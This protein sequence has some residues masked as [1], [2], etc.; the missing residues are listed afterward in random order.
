LRG[1]QA[2]RVADLRFELRERERILLQPL[3]GVLAALANA[4]GLVRVPGARLL[5]E[6]LLDACIQQAGGTS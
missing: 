2:E 5:D 6:I 3:L 1:A 4:L